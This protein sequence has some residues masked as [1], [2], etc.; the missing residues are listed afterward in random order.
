MTGKSIDELGA[1]QREA[2]E[3]IWSLGQAT[4]HQVRD[5]LNK[6]RDL[7]YTTV[8]TAMQKLEKAGLLKHQREGK[9]YVY[10]PAQSR[11]KSQHKNRAQ[12]RQERL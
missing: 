12:I 10:L 8:L 11:E 2:L 9:T 1:L 6:D 3:I 4:V 5:E 7:A